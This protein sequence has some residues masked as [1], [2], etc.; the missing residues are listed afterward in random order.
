MT[1][2][3]RDLLRKALHDGISLRTFLAFYNNSVFK[4]LL[5]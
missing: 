3:R 2:Q 5:D 1:G 4:K